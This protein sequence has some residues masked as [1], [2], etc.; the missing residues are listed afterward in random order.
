MTLE[1]Q[2][3]KVLAIILDEDDEL[4][5]CLFVK[6]EDDV[7][8]VSKFGKGLRVQNRE[9][10]TMGRATHG[11]RAMKLSEGDEIVGLVKVEEDKRVLMVT[12]KGKGKQVRYSEFMAH[13]RGTMGQRI[14]NISEA[15]GYIVNALSVNE[16]NDVVF[17]TLFGQTIRVHV[18]DVS[19]QGRN[20]QGIRVVAF[21][22]D[23]DS[24]VAM[25]CT[26]YQEEAEE[27]I[28]ENAVINTEETEQVDTV[29]EGY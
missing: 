24:L 13:G 25:D 1:M 27:E 8:F 5:S 9:V 26:E 29:A 16:D 19:I 11:V 22:K 10:R 21:K 20:A 28:E 17:V 3:L 18:K 14:Y 4:V 6:E 7:M 12:D 15:N 23:T 2:K